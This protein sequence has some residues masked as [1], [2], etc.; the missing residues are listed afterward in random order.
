[1]YREEGAAFNDLTSD[2]AHAAFG[3]FAQSFNVGHLETPY[4][5]AEFPPPVLEEC[6]TTK[7]SWSFQTTAT[8]RKG[9]V[10][11][12]QGVR[13]QTEYKKAAP[14]EEDAA[15][16]KMTTKAGPSAKPASQA[17]PPEADRS[18]HQRKTPQE[19]LE[20]RRS[21]KRL[22]DHVRNAQEELTGGPKDFRERQLEKKKD[23][24]TKLHGAAKDKEDGTMELSDAALYGGEDKQS[25]QSALA[26]EKQRKA[27]REDRRTSRID[28]LKE[29]ERERQE[30][31][32]KTLGLDGLKAGQ[33]ITIAPRKD[34]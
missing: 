33:K 34:T 31:M 22:R 10:I 32:L 27:Q 25:F 4:Y 18:F 3:R 15:K 11:L 1:L 20:E 5:D 19:H 28:E 26:R 12:Q 6:K 8:E 21:N 30:N 14:T 24:A 17:P 13:T 7:H 29:K 2:Q 23:Q 16:I 9:L